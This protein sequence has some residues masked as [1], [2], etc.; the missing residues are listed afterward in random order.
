MMKKR[1]Y[2]NF[3][4]LTIFIVSILI[5]QLAMG[6]VKIDFVPTQTGTYVLV[7]K[8]PTS[9]Q[10]DL[11]LD[12]IQNGSFS[13]VNSTT[14][15]TGISHYKIVTVPISLKN[16]QIV[17]KILLIPMSQNGG[18]NSFTNIYM[19]DADLQNVTSIINI[20]ASTLVS[21]PIVIKNDRGLYLVLG[22]ENSSGNTLSIY[23]I[24][25]T[26]NSASLF[27]TFNFNKII[28]ILPFDTNSL[29]VVTRDASNNV[30]AKIFSISK[31]E[32]VHQYQLTS[33][34]N[35]RIEYDPDT[36]KT[37]IVSDLDNIDIT[38]A[39]SLYGVVKIL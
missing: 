6:L 20:S 31:N 19:M 4:V 14:I 17:D 15:N 22:L 26:N 25:T 16:N 11:E 27:N 28:N 30:F 34:Q 8:E 39:P 32:V 13:V 18:A 29:V 33:S 21:D 24:D 5:N 37:S 12:T 35:V 23:K 10:L 1:K 2:L 7:A 3:K 38:K 36:F 9:G